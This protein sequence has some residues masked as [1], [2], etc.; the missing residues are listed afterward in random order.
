MSKTIE[1]ITKCLKRLLVC[2]GNQLQYVNL[3]NKN[4]VLFFL[5]LAGEAPYHI[6]MFSVA[7]RNLPNDNYKVIDIQDG[8][9]IYIRKIDLLKNSPTKLNNIKK[10]LV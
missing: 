8:N 4:A 6:G 1:I 5:C 9:Y 3:P 2:E 10:L 7:D